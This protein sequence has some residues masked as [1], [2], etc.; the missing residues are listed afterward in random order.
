MF[1]KVPCDRPSQREATVSR[2]ALIGGF[3]SVAS[4]LALG[5]CANLDAA[6]ARFDASALSLD[7]TLLIAT[8]GFRGAFRVMPTRPTP[9]SAGGS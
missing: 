5:G 1:P 4:V 9:A 2:R 3:A 8:C 7:P 6:G